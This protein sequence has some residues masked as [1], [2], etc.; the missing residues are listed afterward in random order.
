MK[1][2]VENIPA[3]P[4]VYMRRTGAY[5]G[6][7]YKLMQDMKNWIQDNNLWDSDGI[8]YGIAQ[9]NAAITPPE[10]CRYDVCFATE[11]T[12]EDAVIHHGTIPPGTYLVLAIPHTAD[13]V[14]GF[15]ASIGNV[16]AKEGKQIDESRLIL[17]RYQFALVE[18]GY[19]EFCVPILA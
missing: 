10:Q 11:R 16:I 2:H 6:Q 13:E 14:G 3:S 12:F 4:I 5:G 8:I 15:W 1:I 18:N 7:N 9:D 17:E 19:C